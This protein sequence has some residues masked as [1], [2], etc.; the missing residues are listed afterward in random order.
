MLFKRRGIFSMSANRVVDQIHDY[1]DMHHNRYGY[2]IS[3]NELIMFRRRDASVEKW[4][5]LD[6]S[7]SIPITTKKGKLNA[8]MVLWYFHVKYA[9]MELEGGWRLDS[10]YDDCPTSLLGTS[11]NVTTK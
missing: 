7:P 3:H 1:M 5:Q 6:F 10:T 2:I 11:V 8:M 9:V 4:G